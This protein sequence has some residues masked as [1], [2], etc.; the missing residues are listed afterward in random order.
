MEHARAELIVGLRTPEGAR[1]IA[2]PKKSNAVYLDLERPVDLRRLQDAD[3]FLRAHAGKLVVIEEI[4]R[5]PGL[6]EILRGIIDDLRRAGDR[7]GHFLLLGSAAL[8]LMKQTSET[9]AG[10][11]ESK[12]T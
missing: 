6:F 12:A 8:D 9:L 4:H 1:A 2:A 10:R 11:V 3:A 7:A 5:A